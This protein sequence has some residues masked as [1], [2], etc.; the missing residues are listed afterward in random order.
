VKKIERS[1]EK[2]DSKSIGGV[3]GGGNFNTTLNSSKTLENAK[4][5]LHHDNNQVS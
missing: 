4:N 2:I 5:S 1:Q 3:N